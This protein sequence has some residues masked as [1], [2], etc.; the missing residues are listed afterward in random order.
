MKVGRLDAAAAAAASAATE[1]GQN[2]SALGG[3]EDAAEE[4]AAAAAAEGEVSEAANS[5]KARPAARR[6]GAAPVFFASSL[7]HSFYP[8]ANLP[9]PSRQHSP[10]PLQSH[11]K[12]YLLC[13][14]SLA[15][16]SFPKFIAWSLCLVFFTAF[17]PNIC[18]RHLRL[19]FL[20]PSFLLALS[21]L[22][23]TLFFSFAPFSLCLFVF[24]SLSVLSLSICLCSSCVFVLR[25]SLYIS[26]SLKID[27]SN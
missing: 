6:R 4:A 16:I 26:E 22:Y 25:L 15:R 17:I 9:S 18:L 20:Y 8:F 1:A 19:P 2:S 14:P 5:T 23:I 11:T 13:P 24:L 12:S 7:A 10:L 21:I 27:S 3:G